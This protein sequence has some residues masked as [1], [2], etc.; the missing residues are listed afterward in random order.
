MLDRVAKLNSQFTEIKFIPF[1]LSFQLQ[2]CTKST[3]ICFPNKLQYTP[4]SKSKK[5][6]DYAEQFILYLF[7]FIYLRERGKVVHLRSWANKVEKS[8]QKIRLQRDKQN[9]RK[10]LISPKKFSYKS[11]TIDCFLETWATDLNPLPCVPIYWK[12][13]SLLR[14]L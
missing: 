4:L 10:M 8:P 14:L 9:V 2:N 1:V 11:N 5:N 6:L 7:V 13:I 12:K 3:R